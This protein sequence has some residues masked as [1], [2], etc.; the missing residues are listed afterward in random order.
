MKQSFQNVVSRAVSASFSMKM[1]MLVDI[2]EFKSTLVGSSE[3]FVKTKILFEKKEQVKQEDNAII[4][5]F[6]I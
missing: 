5:I 3:S 6:C 4:K 1:N 2:Y